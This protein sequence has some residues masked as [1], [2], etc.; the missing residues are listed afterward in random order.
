M[1]LADIYEIL[2]GKKTFDGTR[3]HVYDASNSELTD[4]L[5]VLWRAN[6]GALLM[7]P[8]DTRL[9]YWDGSQWVP[10]TLEYWDGATWQM[11]QLKYWDGSAWV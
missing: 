7:W 10:K 3:W 4:P 6:P 2:V 9:K 5:G 11:G 8:T 1:T